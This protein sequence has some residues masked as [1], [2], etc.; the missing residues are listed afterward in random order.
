MEKEKG[1]TECEKPSSAQ[2][3]SVNTFDTSTHIND[4]YIFITKTLQGPSSS[5]DIQV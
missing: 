4:Y 1:Q 5:D 2:V 3:S